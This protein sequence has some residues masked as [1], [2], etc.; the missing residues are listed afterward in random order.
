MS[1]LIKKANKLAKKL[2]ISVSASSG[3]GKTYSS[4]LLA[5]GLTGDWDKIVVIDSENDSAS[6][7]ADLGDYNTLS[8]KAPYTPERYIE[9]IRF[10]EDAGYEVIIIDSTTHEWVG[11]GGCL[12]IVAELGGEYRHWSKVTPRHNKFIDAIT[13]SKCHVICTIRRKESYAMS[14][15]SDGKLKIQKLGLEE[16]QRD[17]FSYEMDVV[18]EVDNHNHF[19]HQSKD[20]TGLFVNRDDF[21]ITSETGVELKEWANKGRSLL[22]DAM[23]SLR[24]VDSRT[25]FAKVWKTYSSLQTNED[26]KTLAAIKNKEY[27]KEEVKPLENVQETES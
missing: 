21:L 14:S 6:L 7:Y 26:F 5:Y 17:G 11:R 20:R 18:F 12:E 16:V 13:G 2:R 27:P 23:D 1:F 24:K 25:S 9:A 3:A 22:D 15:G 19:A 10:C 8:L 4:L